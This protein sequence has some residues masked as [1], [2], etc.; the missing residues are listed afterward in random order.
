MYKA[1]LFEGRMPMPFQQPPQSMKSLVFL[2]LL[3]LATGRKIHVREL[4]YGFCEGSPQP[5][6]IDEVVLEPYPV[7]VQTGATI[8]LAIGIT[9][10]E[11]IPVGATAKLKIVRDGLIDIP[12]PCLDIGDI[13]IGSW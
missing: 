4:Q 9:L 5:F 8:H 10:N 6:S 3:A 11:P 2:S 1:S 7:V 13:S 12:L